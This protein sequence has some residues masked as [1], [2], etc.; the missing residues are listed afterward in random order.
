MATFSSGA[1]KECFEHARIE[2]IARENR[3]LI[4]RGR[5]E[6]ALEKLGNGAAAFEQRPPTNHSADQEQ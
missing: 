3:L 6:N 4:K 2:I 1:Q 5:A